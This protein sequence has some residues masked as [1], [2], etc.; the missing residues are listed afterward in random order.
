MIQALRPGGWLLLEDAAPGLRPLLCPDESGPEQRLANRVRSGTAYLSQPNDS[1]TARC[2]FSYS[3][4]R[5]PGSIVGIHC[6][7]RCQ[8]R[9]SPSRSGQ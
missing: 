7:A 1:S 9:R 2:Q 5:R 8:L 6:P 4:C 3:A